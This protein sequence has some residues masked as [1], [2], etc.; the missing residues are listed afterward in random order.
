MTSSSQKMIL[1]AQ[2]VAVIIVAALWLTDAIP[3]WVAGIIIL[4]EVAG[5]VTTN[6]IVQAKQPRSIQEQVDARS[7]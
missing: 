7:R 6:R 1:M 4:A 5:A 2:A 3:G